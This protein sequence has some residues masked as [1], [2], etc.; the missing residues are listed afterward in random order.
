MIVLGDEGDDDGGGGRREEAGPAGEG[1][2]AAE[3]A[4][5]TVGR[6]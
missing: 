6:V 3:A 1:A 4:A 2:H 5:G